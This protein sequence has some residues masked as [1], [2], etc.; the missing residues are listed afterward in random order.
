MKVPVTCHSE[1]QF[2]S[3][4]FYFIFL[5]LDRPYTVFVTGDKPNTVNHSS[6][7][8]QSSSE[9]LLHF[10]YSSVWPWQWWWSLWRIQQMIPQYQSILSHMWSPC[11]KMRKDSYC[12]KSL[13]C[14]LHTSLP[15]RICRPTWESMSMYVNICLISDKHFKQSCLCL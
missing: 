5:I 1:A 4:W 6:S 9:C 15:A 11:F 10:F 14:L 2:C 8:C 7:A 12:F 3:R 13:L